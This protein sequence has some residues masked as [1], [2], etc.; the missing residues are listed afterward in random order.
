[1]LASQNSIFVVEVKQFV[2][3][4]DVEQ[5]EDKRKEEKD[6]L[7]CREEVK[8]V[9]ELYRNPWYINNLNINY[10][11]HVSFHFIGTTVRK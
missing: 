9:S 6:E 7:Q 11:F 2:E 1:M 3:I 8:I 5:E 4:I 10:F